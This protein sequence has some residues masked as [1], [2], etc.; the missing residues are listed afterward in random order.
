MEN[1]ITSAVQLYLEVED[2]ML[3]LRRKSSWC[4]LHM[5]VLRELYP[6]KCKNGKMIP[7][8]VLAHYHNLSIEEI[9]RIL[10]ESKSIP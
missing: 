4:Y 5:A 8:N 3:I 10:A 1:K 7:T 6:E 9:G 2:I